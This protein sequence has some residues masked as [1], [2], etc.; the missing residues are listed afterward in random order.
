MKLYQY[1]SYV[2]ALEGA[3]DVGGMYIG[4]EKDT[5]SLRNYG[6]YL[7]IGGIGHPAGKK[8]E[9]FLKLEQ[10]KKRFYPEAREKY[11]F[12]AQDCIPLDDM[13]YIGLYSKHMPHLYA[14]TGFQKWGM[15]LSMV[16][17]KLISALILGEHSPYEAL[18]SPSR[19]MIRPRLFANGIR[20]AAGLLTPTVPRCPHMGCALKWNPEE[21]TW[22]CPCH[23]SRFTEKGE[24]LDNPSVKDLTV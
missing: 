10:E 23:G 24:L 21:K 9:G 18:L 8:G 6:N 13:P 5:L 11:R 2:M 17:A 12:G 14:I 1:R 3:E 22:D 20:T 7:L 19:S 15:T 16:G 4:L